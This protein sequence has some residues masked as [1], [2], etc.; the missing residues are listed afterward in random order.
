MYTYVCIYIYTCIHV[1]I[2]IWIYVCIYIHM[3]YICIYIHTYIY[4]TCI[5]VYMHIYIQIWIYVCMC[6]Y[7]YL[8]VLPQHIYYTITSKNHLSSRVAVLSL[9]VRARELSV[10]AWQYTILYLHIYTTFSHQDHPLQ[11]CTTAPRVCA[12]ARAR[13]CSVD[14][15]PDTRVW[16]FPVRT[17]WVQFFDFFSLLEG[18]LND[19]LTE[20]HKISRNEMFCSW[21]PFFW[22]QVMLNTRSFK[23]PND[24]D[25]SQHYSNPK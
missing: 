11:S 14:L 13:E 10:G 6:I 17:P 3:Y 5:H 8:Y 21:F 12:R 7:M 24:K 4:I 1:Y 9:W 16:Q 15:W 23:E 22:G 2:Y 25:C 20:S 18:K 19:I